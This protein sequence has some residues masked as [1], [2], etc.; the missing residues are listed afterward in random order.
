MSERQNITIYDNLSKEDKKKFEDIKNI[1]SKRYTLLLKKDED[2]SAIYPDGK[3]LNYGAILKGSWKLESLKARKSKENVRNEI[4]GIK[5]TSHSIVYSG[6]KVYIDEYEVLDDAYP[7]F[8]NVNVGGILILAN[9]KTS[10]ITGGK[11]FGGFI[12]NNEMLGADNIKNYMNEQI[13][14]IYGGYKLDSDEYG[15][16]EEWKK[17]I[18]GCE[19]EKKKS[20]IIKPVVGGKGKEEEHFDLLFNIVTGNP[21]YQM[22]MLETITSIPLLKQSIFNDTYYNFTSLAK[23]IDTG[24]LK[25]QQGYEKFFLASLLNKMVNDMKIGEGSIQN[26]DKIKFEKPFLSGL[27]GGHHKH[28]HHHEH[29]KEKD[30]LSAM[31]MF[32]IHPEINMWH[33]SMFSKGDWLD[34]YKN[35]LMINDPAMIINRMRNY[36]L[37]YDL[38]NISSIFGGEE[39]NYDSLGLDKEITGA[40]KLLSRVMRGGG[41]TT[42]EKINNA[43]KLIFTKFAQMSEQAKLLLEGKLTEEKFKEMATV[44]F[45]DEKS[46][47]DVSGGGLW[48]TY[49]SMMK[50]NPLTQLMGSKYTD[51][52]RLVFLNLLSSVEKTYSFFKQ[53]ELANGKHLTWWKAIDGGRKVNG[54]YDLKDE[55]DYAAIAGDMELRK[56]ILDDFIAKWVDLATAK[57]IPSNPT[58]DKYEPVITVSTGTE[59]RNFIYPLGKHLTF[60]NLHRDFKESLKLLFTPNVFKLL[61][62]ELVKDNTK[63]NKITELVK[64]DGIIATYF[65]KFKLVEAN[66]IKKL[67]EELVNIFIEA[68]KP[69]VTSDK[70]SLLTKV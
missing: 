8:E 18:G 31:M 56:K 23:N 33:D 15:T 43:L 49:T 48:E 52:G 10:G 63:D 5:K 47:E 27:F 55:S 24:L 60:L 70:V 7:G 6:D 50:F 64:P 2:I 28:H 4:R 32:G 41:A 37:L 38:T 13:S 51:V 17:F 34:L 26:L 30:I 39:I 68:L 16:D 62:T 11:I 46:F 69:V 14:K 12:M 67:T 19:E 45:I 9:E 53:K 22:K 58:N 57:V 35:Y 54:L 20:Q 1:L 36:D 42:E 40:M 21:P 59:Q 66:A 29:K 44:P 65:G 25:D 61:I 3:T